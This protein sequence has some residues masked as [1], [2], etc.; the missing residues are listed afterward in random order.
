MQRR[1]ILKT[2][3]I[4]GLAAGAGGTAAK[5]QTAAQTFVL[6][7]GAWHGGWCWNK[8]IPHLESSGHRALAVTLTGQGDRA[9]LINPSIDLAT[10]IADVVSMLEM[11][12]LRDV[13]LVGTTPVCPR[14]SGA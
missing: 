2:M 7:H 4:A 13:V 10:H 11:D 6:V 12:D 8:L 5:A 3:A 1:D 14:I 9:H